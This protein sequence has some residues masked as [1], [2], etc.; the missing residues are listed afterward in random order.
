MNLNIQSIRQKSDALEILLVEEDID[1]VTVSEHWLDSE[2]MS[3]FQI[4]NYRVAGYSVRTDRKGGGTLIL[5]R[6][7]YEVVD[8]P[9]VRNY[10]IESHI[11]LCAVDVSQIKTIF[12]SVYR[13]P[14]GKVEIFMENLIAVLN[15]ITETYVGRKIVMAGDFNIDLNGSG[16]D[17]DELLNIAN[18]Y[19][20]MR[21]IN[22][23][24]RIST[25]RTCI[26]NVFTDYEGDITV[27]IVESHMSDHLAQIVRIEL[28]N[29]ISEA[30]DTIRQVRNINKDQVD[31][32]RNMLSDVS[33]N[34]VLQHGTAQEKFTAFQYTIETIYDICFP[35]INGKITNNNNCVWKTQEVKA[36][37]NRLDA[38]Y[39]IFEVTKDQ[40]VLDAYKQ[41]KIRYQE[42]ISNAKRKKYES[43]IATSENRQQTIWKII[44]QE[45]G[46]RRR[47]DV[48]NQTELTPEAFNN[49]FVQMGDSTLRQIDVSDEDPR[50]LLE[51]IGLSPVNSFYVGP[52][53]KR[54]VEN[55]IQNM[56]KKRTK[57]IYGLSTALLK[58]IVVEIAEPLSIAVNYC[59]EEGVFPKEMKL[60]RVAPV[61]KK[62]DKTKEEN[63]R[64]ISVL[65][66]FS[67]V[68]EAAIR[69]RLVAFF[70]KENIFTPAQHGYMSGKSTVTA[71][72]EALEEILAARD[73]GEPIEMV[74][75]DLSKAFDTVPH[76]LLLEKLYYYGV[77]G[78]SYKLLKSYIEDRKQ[79]VSWNNTMSETK[80]VSSGVP[81]GSILG[82]LLFIMYIN[83]LP[84]NVPNS[85]VC[86][87]ADDTSFIVR[88]GEADVAMAAAKRWFDANKLKMNVD[89][90]QVLAFPAAANGGVVTFLGVMVDGRLNWSEHV[91]SL[92][93]RL[94]SAVYTIRRIK[95]LVTHE[96]A[97]LAYYANFHSVAS[98]GILVWGGS[99]GLQMVLK[100]QKRAVRALC[101]LRST[102]SCRE[103]FIKEK[104]MT[105][106]NVYILCCIKHVYRNRSEIKTN[107][108][109]HGYS[110][111]HRDDFTIPHHRL[112]QT[113]QSPVYCGV[114]FYNKLPEHFKELNAR[115]FNETVK[116]LFLKHAFYSTD[117]YLENDFN[118]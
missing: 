66:V 43:Q 22:E 19:G 93:P 4:D 23:T 67:K 47:F 61:Y 52:V 102:D 14:A 1:V 82:P 2:S 12:L 96:A 90:T 31:L 116:D 88:R 78:T 3:V 9:E 20:L 18:M 103:V 91:S 42:M 28:M 79:A 76:R 30:K 39:T 86:L 16:R 117:E 100:L 63:Y 33:W 113:Q 64:P 75:N 27:K 69:K 49:Y 24:T 36:S 54:E 114:K 89:K 26:D 51:N 29:A 34:S 80:Y 17:R 85:K 25:A 37:K 84:I 118:L 98:Y 107:A 62:G 32:F 109:F 94:G 50:N 105:I 15:I 11:E 35:V 97:K 106:V 87:Y 38:L 101:G 44:N 71:L 72:V 68:M 48:G 104:I 7:K 112:K 99:P 13:P 74:L 21:I 46:K 56:R 60:A 70:E 73:G 58:D 81:Q 111:R 10:T 40:R 92:T 6:D 83:D 59:I 55:I 5:V 41:E 8:I 95:Q 110:T 57:D 65:P 108:D 115:N 53:D 45:S 77:R